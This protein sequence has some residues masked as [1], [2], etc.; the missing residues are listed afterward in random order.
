MKTVGCCAVFRGITLGQI[1]VS[2]YRLKKIVEV[3]SNATGKRADRLHLLSLLKLG[4]EALLL[5]LHLAPLGDVASVDDPEWFPV[6]IDVD[7]GQSVQD[8]PGT[9]LVLYSHCCGLRCLGIGE[10]TCHLFLDGLPV[11]RVNELE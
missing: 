1:S 5:L 11:V 4:V 7:V 2:E 8:T 6:A 9:V 10:G 3:V